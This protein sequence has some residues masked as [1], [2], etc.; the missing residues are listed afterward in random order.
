MEV[1]P[2]DD[3]TFCCGSSDTCCGSNAAFT[4]PSPSQTTPTPATVT[5]TA[6]SESVRVRDQ[7]PLA[8]YLGMG[9]GILA[10]LL[11]SL[12]VII[13]LLRQVR[14]LRRRN[15][16]LLGS[17]AIRGSKAPVL[18]PTP[19]VGSM[20]GFADFRSTYGDLIA[21]REAERAERLGEV[22]GSERAAVESS[23]RSDTETVVGSALSPAGREERDSIGKVP[24][25]P[26]RAQQGT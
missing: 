1:T 18:P 22:A 3:G 25:I 23:L 21:K 11:V 26:P 7:A 12:G 24:P 17:A 5:A 9:G 13:F 6:T 15:G 19:H 14:M 4:P 16:E 8:V 10:V 20:Q 2:C